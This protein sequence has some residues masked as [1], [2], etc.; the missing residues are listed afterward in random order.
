[1]MMTETINMMKET[2]KMMTKTNKIKTLWEHKLK[3]NALSCP[4]GE[5]QAVMFSML[6]LSMW[7]ASP[8]QRFCCCWNKAFQ[9]VQSAVW[10]GQVLELENRVGPH[11][12]AGLAKGDRLQDE[13][14]SLQSGGQL[15]TF[16]LA[17]YGYFWLFIAISGYFRILL[18]NS[19]YFWLHL[20]ISGY[21]YNFRLFLAISGYFWLFSTISNHPD[22]PEIYFSMNN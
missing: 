20:A 8:L 17:I 14:Q 22:H 4:T 7:T 15:Q 5:S 18:A 6:R 12:W 1:M 3:Q 10:S 9:G 21:L 2:M 13:G 11:G 19:S 16:F